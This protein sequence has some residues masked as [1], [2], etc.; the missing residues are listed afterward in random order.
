M[1]VN[2]NTENQDIDSLSR[3]AI[4]SH[5]DVNYFVEA[6]A[7]SGK[8]TM[9]VN[10]M[11]AM[12]ES[13]I[14]IQKICAITFTKAAAGEF[15]NR[16]Q[17]I[18]IKRSSDKYE[19]KA[20]HYPGQ[21][22]KP[23]DETRKLCEK[24]LRNIDL[25]FMGT[26]DSFCNM[27][28]SEHPS[29]AG[30]PADV[31]VMDKTAMDALYKQ[32]YVKISEGV[33]GEELLQY[34]KL[35]RSLFWTPEDVF[36]LGIGTFMEN[37]NVHMNYNE[38]PIVS[39]D[40]M[41]AEDRDKIIS[42]IQAI[43]RHPDKINTRDNSSRNAAL[44]L[45]TL[46]RRITGRW[47]NNLQSVMYALG[48]INKL[49]IWGRP[50]DIGL[51]NDELFK[52]DYSGFSTLRLDQENGVLRRLKSIQ[53]DIAMTFLG[54]C[55]P[56]IE[57]VLLKKG[58]FTYFDY[59]YFLRNMLRKSAAG[60]GKLIDYIYNRHS[61]FLIDEF[62]DTNPIQAEIF[63]YLS[64]QN[65]VE[66]W[67]NCVPRP[68]SLFIV[69]DPKQSIYRF[70]SAD[71][72]SFLRVKQLFDN[73]VGQKLTLSRNF[74]SVRQL[75]KYFNDSFTRLLPTETQTQSKYSPIPLKD[76][77]EVGV[78][79]G[80]YKYKAYFGLAAAGNP[81]MS[82]VVR[83]GNIIKTL[84]NNPAYLIKGAEDDIPRQIQYSDFMIITTA[85]K[86]IGGFIEHFKNTDIPLKVEGK[87]PF[88]SNVAL[89]EIYKIYSC[90]ARP[91]DA[92]ALYG[93]LNSKLLGF[94]NN[95]I[96][97]Y[98][99]QGY[100]L[101]LISKEDTDKEIE[102]SVAQIAEAVRKLKNLRYKANKLSPA[103]LFSEIMDSFEIYKKLSCENL[104]VVFYTMELLRDAEKNR[105]II[106]IRD[107]VDYLKILM[108]GTSEVERCLGLRQDRD[109][110]H[111]ANL[112][113]VKGLEAPIVILSYAYPNP[114]SPTFR[115]E[116]LQDETQGYLF[117]LQKDFTSVCSTNMY[118]DKRAAEEQGLKDET[119]RLIY[120]AATRARN[121]LIICESVMVTRDK[122]IV[123][124]RWKPLLGAD[125]EDFFETIIPAANQ[126]VVVHEKVT[127]NS[128]YETAK[129][130]NVLENRLHEN[131]SYNIKL[132][133][134]IKVKSKVE[135]IYESDANDDKAGADD[136]NSIKAL[137][138][139][140]KYAALLGTMTHRLM[141][142]LVTTKNSVNADE[143]VA[144]IFK[145]YA[146]PEVLPL[147]DDVIKALLNV[148]H[149]IRNGGFSQNNGVTND[150]LT[151]LLDAKEVMCEVPFC[152]KDGAAG[153]DIWNGIID[154]MYRNESGWHI[155]DYKTN[156]D[157][158]NLDTVYEG[159]LD[160]YK[161]AFKVM[162]GEDADANIYHIDI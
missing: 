161:K 162:S 32:E 27:I 16:F 156:I 40:D 1:D 113:K 2:T 10:R 128:L 96:M 119:D 38:S 36:V 116:Y 151:E 14:D 71:V 8:T 45:K 88:E 92:I 95:D 37:R 104:E 73:S 24:A 132:P 11:V 98:K 158:E 31:T 47:S 33:Y 89:G 154:V 60:D 19:Q 109:C 76:G 80:V 102:A 69:G 152:Y 125:T 56:V 78:F 85:K 54:K 70:R 50:E 44:A 66:K 106:T 68:G 150:I 51:Q 7:G 146:V 138:K 15:Y 136:F 34:A 147:K 43:S 159:Q 111:I 137:Q 155:I 127:A 115:K 62:Q 39:L 101:S 26:I 105:S 63:F 35:F 49:S 28:L 126:D 107:G 83:V 74:R 143:M 17:K 6:G 55:V 114:P 124:T 118:V 121:A 72:T 13:G 84:V 135:D 64:S 46:R 57:E 58:E 123:K 93:A 87:V 97:M 82:D 81:A 86:N 99:K 79:T 134:H 103:S 145:E 59:L 75:C 20:G 148:V 48:E 130:N 140:R 122:E 120:V 61:Y 22:P 108:E 94:S 91:E 153:T 110:V 21:L 42:A 157:N 100:A 142:I 52:V 117:E 5:M 3:E 12:V 29:E 131:P 139:N 9:L 129:G 23:T 4:V 67:Y 149:V 90:V 53:Y 65:P 112:H 25:C 160:A 144:D 18:L 133:S 41:F 141:E 30:I 77:D